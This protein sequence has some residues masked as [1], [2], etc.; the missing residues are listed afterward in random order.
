MNVDEE[1]TE[2]F[3]AVIQKFVEEGG[4]TLG[5]IF[6]VDEQ[7]SLINASLEGFTSQRR[8]HMSQ[9]FR[10]LKITEL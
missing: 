9:D 3:A 6:N 10:L 7:V 8:G 5:P 1:A 2:E 4:Y